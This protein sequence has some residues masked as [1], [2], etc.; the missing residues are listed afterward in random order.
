MK[1]CVFA[2][3]FDPITLGH[4]NIINKCLDR[5][6]R[7]ILVIGQNPKKSTLFTEWQRLEMLKSVYGDNSKVEIVLFSDHKD[8]YADF[9]KSKN[10]TVYVRGIRNEQD[11]AF[12]KQMQQK[13]QIEYPF[14]TTEFIDCDKAFCEISSTKVRQITEKDG[15]YEK[16]LS[17]KVLDLVKRFLVKN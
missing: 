12:E 11:L 7:V 8:D 1:T 6:D 16:Y 5:F 15:S 2:G 4:E 17:L 10:A 9:L 3:T 13:N 14:I